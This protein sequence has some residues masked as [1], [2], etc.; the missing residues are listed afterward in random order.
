MYTFSLS[1]S[2]SFA[3]KSIRYGANHTENLCVC[4]P[5]HLLQ[6]VILFLLDIIAR[7]DQVHFRVLTCWHDEQVVCLYSREERFHL[8]F[9]LLRTRCMR[10]EKT[11]H[12]MTHTHTNTTQRS[13]IRIIPP[14]RKKSTSPFLHSYTQCLI[15][16]HFSHHRHDQSVPCTEYSNVSMSFS[17]A[18]SSQDKSQAKRSWGGEGGAVES[19]EAGCGALYFHELLV[20]EMMVRGSE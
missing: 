15:Q 3:R 19:G 16:P 7:L 13:R 10:E 18:I 4:A 1:P 2:L 12:D 9:V 14:E 17:A 6:T 11:K 20:H 5:P 8:S